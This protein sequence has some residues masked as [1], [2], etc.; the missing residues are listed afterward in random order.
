MKFFYV[1]RL[2]VKLCGLRQGNKSLRQFAQEFMTKAVWHRCEDPTMIAH[3][4][5][6]GLSQKS[7]DRI[8]S[9]GINTLEYAKL[10]DY[11]LQ[12]PDVKSESS[13]AVAK[14]AVHAVQKKKPGKKA[15]WCFAC[16]QEGHILAIVPSKDNGKEMPARNNQKESFILLRLQVLVQNRARKLKLT[17]WPAHTEWVDAITSIIIQTPLNLLLTR[18]H[19]TTWQQK[20]ALPR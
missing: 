7:K 16:D 15:M 4:F 6:N 20:Q 14:S 2:F 3:A 17:L 12:T 5:M 19:R 10:V 8:F 18:V 1:G 9:A 11:C 13:E